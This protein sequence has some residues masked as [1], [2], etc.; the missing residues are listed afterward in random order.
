MSK[1]QIPENHRKRIEFINLFVKN[2]RL[3]QVLTQR[4]FSEIADIHVN[5]LQKFEKNNSNISILTLFSILDAME[6]MT[7][8]EFF[9]GME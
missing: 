9:S 3:N 8:S 7:L 4:E 1:K 5:T 6:G 2:W